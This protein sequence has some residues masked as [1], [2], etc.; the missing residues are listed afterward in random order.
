MKDGDKRKHILRTLPR[1][2]QK[3]YITITD[4]I[5]ENVCL[6]QRTPTEKYL[7]YNTMGFEVERQNQVIVAMY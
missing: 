1:F 7:Q 2:K 4:L 6:S 3:T 5:C